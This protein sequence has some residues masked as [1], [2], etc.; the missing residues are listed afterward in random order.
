M[1]PETIY[2][3]SSAVSS[4]EEAELQ[5]RLLCLAQAGGATRVRDV[6][7]KHFTEYSIKSALEEFEPVWLVPEIWV[8][9]DDIHG[10]RDPEQ[11]TQDGVRTL[12]DC[13]R[14]HFGDFIIV[15]LSSAAEL[16]HEL[17][18]IAGKRPI[19]ISFDHDLGPD[20]DGA[21]VA[22]VL[23]NYLDTY[24]LSLP[25]YHVHSA[26]APGGDNIVSIMETYEKARK[27]ILQMPG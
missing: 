15:K 23:C 10:P 17:G 1:I 5:Y 16:S 26:N 2:I 27:L 11:F 4:A 21:E 18:R 22:R 7:G 24:G 13:L 3:K 6:K 20:M 12:G 9:D 8:L 25:M 14:D 19:G